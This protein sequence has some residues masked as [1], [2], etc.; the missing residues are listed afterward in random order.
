M[1]LLLLISL[2]VA[3]G[4]AKSSK[5]TQNT[6]EGT[7]TL[8]S[9]T[10]DNSDQYAIKLFNDASNT[11]FL[12]S[13][14]RFSVNNKGTYTIKEADCN[15]GKRYFEYSVDPTKQTSGLYDFLIRPT[16]ASGNSQTNA[17][18]RTKMIYKTS[19]KMQWQQT[20][21]VNGK[22]FVFKM[23]FEKS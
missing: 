23:N 2:V 22:P 16:D 13:R 15:P 5:T 1:T 12:G 17:A 20:T 10:Y 4:A 14:W 7:W 6:L 8:S 19:E 3:C 21:T 18:Y 11:C 9:I